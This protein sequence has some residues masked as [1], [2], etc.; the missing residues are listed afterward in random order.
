MHDQA[1]KINAEIL[2]FARRKNQYFEPLFFISG[3]NRSQIRSDRSDL[4]DLIT[5]NRSTRS[6]IPQRK[7]D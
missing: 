5:I 2:G 1:E 7:N 6:D 4:V 3:T